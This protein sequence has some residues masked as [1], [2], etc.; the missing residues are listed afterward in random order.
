M[1]EEPTYEQI[2]TAVQSYIKA[3]RLLGRRDTCVGKIATDLGLSVEQVDGAFS[4]FNI[5]GAKLDENIKRYHTRLSTVLTP[6][7]NIKPL[8]R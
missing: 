7:V 8:K 4:R 1:V 3:L 6:V 2:A 5:I